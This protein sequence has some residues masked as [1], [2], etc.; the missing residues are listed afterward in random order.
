MA[1]LRSIGKLLLVSLIV[2]TSYASFDFS[3]QEMPDKDQSVGQVLYK[4]TVV[5]QLYT[6]GPFVTNYSRAQMIA[7]RLNE[8]IN[9]PEDINKIRLSYP[10]NIYTATIEGRNLFSVFKEDSKQKNMKAEAIMAEWINN[11]KVA[12][13]PKDL[14]VTENEKQVVLTK[15]VVEKKQTAEKQQ[16]PTIASPVIKSTEVVVIPTIAPTE[17]KL[18]VRDMFLDDFEERLAKIEKKVA[19]SVKKAKGFSW[20]WL[21]TLI[22]LGL[23][24]Y[25]LFIYRK[26]KKHLGTYEEVEQTGRMEEIE[27]SVSVLIKE[28]KDVSGEAADNVIKNIKEQNEA[29]QPTLP[30]E[31]VVLEQETQTAEEEI[32]IEET[33]EIIEEEIPDIAEKDIVPEVET[34]EETALADSLEEALEENNGTVVMKK[35]D[36]EE[37]EKEVEVEE[38]KVEEVVPQ[39]KEAP[40]QEKTP[41]KAKS[42][43]EKLA[44]ELDGG[45]K[46]EEAKPS[47]NV[48]PTNLSGLG[49]AELFKILSQLDKE[50]RDEVK[51][52]LNNKTLNKNEKIIKMKQLEMD[53]DLIAKVLGI[54]KEEVNLVLQLNDMEGKTE[55]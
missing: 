53:N 20:I 12:M 45:V 14:V 54:G 26:I 8:Y 16:K 47:I 37:L 30:I 10:E 27:N 32:I 39:V 34:K 55:A 36:L 43:A 38:E 4:D 25:L 5:M 13:I 17:E 24:I 41:S 7:Y 9:S 50:I 33:V 22:N 31:E 6:A 1:R 3:A 35:E 42:D 29:S 18:A 52:V 11:I 40:V 48:N 44:E 19:G 2:A 15:E 21:F 46:A 23:G 49:M 28:L 51:T